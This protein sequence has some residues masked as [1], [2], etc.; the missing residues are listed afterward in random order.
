MIKNH[1]QIQRLKKI[2]AKV[3]SFE[4]EMAG[5]SDADL[6]KKTQE[7]KERLTAGETLDDLLPEAYAVV[8]EADKRVLGMFPYDVQVMGAIVL[9][10]G[11]VAEMATGEGK[12]LTAT[13]PLYLNALSGQGAMLVTTN[14]YLALRDAQEMGQVYRFLGLTIEAAVVADETE[15]LTPKQKRLIYQ[16]DIVYTTNS[17]LGFD[18]L[19]ENLAENKDSQYLSPFNY[20][21]IDEIDS[22]LLDSAQVPLVISGAPRVQSNFYS[23]M[24]TFITTLKEEEDYHYDDEKNEVWLTSKGILAAESFL[25]LEHLFSK[26]NQ[27]LVR[28]LNLALRAHKLYKKDKDYVVRQGDKETEVVLLDRSTGRLLEMTRLQGGQHQAIEAKEHVKLTEETRAMASI[29]Y[30]N[31][32]RLFR[33]I[34][35]MT[36]TGKVVESEF[37]ETYSMSVIKIPTN[38]PVIRQDL[39]DQLYQT[40]PEK[41]FA[42]LD[43]VKHYHAQGNPLLIFTGSVEMSE[44]YS[45]LLLREGIAH[46]LL[47]AN[48]AAREAQIIAESG[49]KGAVTVATSMAGRGTDIK[50]GP[51]V[52]D[53][54]GLVVIGTERMENQRIDLQI[55]GRSGRQ[56]D[57]G[58]SKFFIS[59]EDDLLRKWGP[60]WLKK[61]YKDYSA[62]EVEQHPVQLGQR[63]FRRLVAKAQ[64][65]SESS[66]KMSR[67]MTLEYAQCM[68]I[69][70][71][72]TYAERNRLI[73]AEERIDEEISRVLSQVIHQAAY[74]QSYETRA[75]LY[76]FILDHFSYHAERIPYDFDIYSP[77]KIAELLQDI[78]EQE[79]QAKKAY[80]KSDKLFTHFQRVSVLKAIDEN[81][82]EQVDYLQ[83]LKTALSGQHFSMKNPLVEYYQEAYDGFEYMK[84]RMKQQIVKNLL[85]SELALNPKGEVIMYFP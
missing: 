8:R 81:W 75:D 15:N 41:V 37:M 59:L 4:S 11:N 29:T 5:L 84:E 85:M 28:H 14:T 3:K 53:L 64:R 21:I 72:I 79:L 63:R 48:N 46:N 66:A 54:G 73:Q 56:G 62:E 38:Q 7:F 49:Q 31:L 70:R 80:L 78:A 44:I 13:M 68:K 82:V 25:D 30:Q 43:E 58:I 55:R 47:N 40:L 61:F 22:I 6:R 23:I 52:A 20:V 65:A 71:E 16:A 1:F 2:L 50:L 39:P 34:S 24:D 10:E 12:T 69:Q 35:G 51:G 36:G 57:P 83:Q 27:E 67:R 18:Y 74:E 42:S 17:A 9:H 77:E 32:F 33:K 45:S 26:E 19:I 76:R 60:D